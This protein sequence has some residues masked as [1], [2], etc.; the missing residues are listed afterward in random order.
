MEVEIM[1][2]GV[3]GMGRAGVVLCAIILVGLTA[4]AAPLQ[5]AE[6][7][8]FG[9]TFTIDSKLLH[10][11]RRINVYL[12]PVYSG[13]PDVRLPVLYMPDGGM[14]EDFLHVAGLVQVSVGNGTMRPFL[15]VGI[16]NTQRRR[17]MTGP[18]ENPED[19]K[20]APKVGESAAFRAFIR[21]ELMPQIKARYRTTEE[22]AI[23]GES[24]AGLFVLE[25]FFLEPDL[26]DTYIAFDP[27]LWWNRETLVVDAPRR[28]R[29]A[30]A[31]EKTVYFASSDEKGIIDPAQ[32]LAS[33][34]TK[35]APPALHWHYEKMPEE[36]HST[37][38][39]PAALRAFRALFKPK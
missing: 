4:S 37:I 10:E 34:L 27:S 29:A 15:V 25:T 1:H 28:L 33:I 17:D 31:H 18:T 9:E 39:H 35:D 19:R 38:Y 5:K 7:L 12:P 23:V 30:T 6:P 3:D 21:Q 16:E 14:A 24:L 36:H 8:V 22:R 13:A 26:F 32:R 2:R 11:T 20:I